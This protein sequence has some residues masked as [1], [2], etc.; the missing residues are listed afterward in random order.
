ME[1]G[2]KQ[3]NMA[4]LE[5]Q[6]NKRDLCNPLEMQDIYQKKGSENFPPTKTFPRVLTP[7]TFSGYDTQSKP[8]NGK[9]KWDMTELLKIIRVMIKTANPFHMTY[10][11][12]VIM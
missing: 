12:S 8:Y 10:F 3:Q 1:K 2:Q 9:G 6:G 5:N 4:K 7:R 11:I